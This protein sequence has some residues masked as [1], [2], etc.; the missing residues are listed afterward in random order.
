MSDWILGPE[1]THRWPT[2]PDLPHPQDT[3][4]Y[5]RLGSLPSTSAKFL[6]PKEPGPLMCRE[7]WG[8]GGAEVRGGPGPCERCGREETP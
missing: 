1:E 3:M 6:P 7:C 4:T 8:L 2:M 5:M